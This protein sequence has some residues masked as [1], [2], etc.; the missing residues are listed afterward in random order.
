MT[1][2]KAILFTRDEVRPTMSPR[3]TFVAEYVNEQTGAGLAGG[4]TAFENAEFAM[5]LWYDE[6]LLALE[7]ETRFEVDTAEA[8]FALGPGDVL[9]LP[10]GL[11]LTYRSVGRTLAFYAI[12]P[13]DWR[14]GLP[15]DRQPTARAIF[16]MRNNVPQN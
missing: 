13:A 10:R 15:A 6:L 7:V 12:A 2:P 3:G 14:T 11:A 4:M 16:A 1:Q 8:R 5:T 9:W